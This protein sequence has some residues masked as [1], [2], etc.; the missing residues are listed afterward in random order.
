MHFLDVDGLR[1]AYQQGGSGPCV[2]L[3]HS[4]FTDSRIWAAQIEALSDQFT[5]LA[6]DAPGCGE[7][8]DP[9]P[10]WT[11][12]DFAALLGRTLDSLEKD[13]VHLVGAAWGSTLALELYRQRPQLVRSLVLTSAYAGWKGSLSAEEVE[14]RL[15]RF[16]TELADPPQ[17][18]IGSWIPTFLTPGAS[19][20]MVDAV[21]DMMLAVH[22]DGAR[23]MAEAMAQS[24]HRALL[25]EIAAPVLVIN[26][27]A[28]R[29]APLAVAEVIHR[30]IPGAKL[31]IIPGAGHLP[32]LE[33][34]EAFNTA[35]RNFLAGL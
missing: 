7:S 19:R 27:E 33:R 16:R 26:G 23:C 12:T 22:P 2:V 21:V 6:W 4:I 35:V 14:R 18:F 9:P 31:E 28:D 30:A 20:E 1:I 29:R 24:D 13:A 10:G 5:V 11:M 25:P 15:T 3:L 17:S 32:Y 34:P 8:A